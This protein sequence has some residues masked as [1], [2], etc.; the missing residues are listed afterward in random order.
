MSRACSFAMLGTASTILWNGCCMMLRLA[1]IENDKLML[2][3]LAQILRSL[4]KGK[5]SRCAFGRT[6][7]TA[8]CENLGNTYRSSLQTRS[9]ATTRFD[10]TMLCK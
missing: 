1:A 2:T 3:L 9:K 4:S 10:G 7:R 6:Q 5:S 8:Q